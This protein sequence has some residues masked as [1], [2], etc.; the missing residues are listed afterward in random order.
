MKKGFTLIELLGIIIILSA[1]IL[2]AVPNITSSLRNS[3]DRLL[4]V[5]LEEIISATKSW[6][7]TNYNNLPVQEG[8]EIRVSLLQLKLANLIPSDIK[9]PKTNE[10]FFDDMQIK[11]TKKGLNYIYSVLTDTGSSNTTTNPLGP[12]IT[13]NGSISEVV[14]INDSEYNEPGATAKDSLNNNIAVSITIKN[15]NNQIVSSINT[16]TLGKYFITYS[17]TKDSY[18]NS[19]TREVSIVDT[20]KPVINVSGYT[21]NQYIELESDNDYTLPPAT[22]SDNSK[23]IL[24]VNIVGNFTT[25]LTGN[26]KVIYEAID[27]SGNKGTFTLNY[28]IKDTRNPE[29]TIELNNNDTTLMTTIIVN[30]KDIGVGLHNYAYSFDGGENYQKENYY[31]FDNETGFNNEII[32]RDKAGN[33][34]TQ[35]FNSLR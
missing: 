15:S 17:A 28:I 35:N 23:E 25:L 8:D 12:T 10:L 13:L 3:K 2:I 21:D 1:I 14:E 30:A 9:N 7:L 33:I 26:K 22:V 6:A 5:Q 18:S 27:S 20:T 24:A 34:A 19:I 11:I 32:V 16:S 31:T 29:F 4:S